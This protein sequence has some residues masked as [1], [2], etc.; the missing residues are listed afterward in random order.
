[1]YTLNKLH[2]GAFP[3]SQQHHCQLKDTS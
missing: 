1:V 2:E 3:D